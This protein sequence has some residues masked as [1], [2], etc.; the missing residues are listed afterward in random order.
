MLCYWDA[1]G[2]GRKETM[3]EVARAGR[4]LPAINRLGAAGA[5]AEGNK[6]HMLIIHSVEG[7]ARSI[8]DMN[9]NGWT[10]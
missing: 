8:V 10:A 3:H 4:D 9:T 1:M 5:E 2:P 6:V 7:E